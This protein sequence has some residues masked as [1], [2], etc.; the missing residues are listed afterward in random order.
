VADRAHQKNLPPSLLHWGNS[1]AFKVA[2]DSLGE[3]ASVVLGVGLFVYPLPSLI[4]AKRT[5]SQCGGACAVLLHS[6]TPVGLIG[7]SF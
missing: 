5:G 4:L 6:Q 2:P 7:K 1:G 3:S